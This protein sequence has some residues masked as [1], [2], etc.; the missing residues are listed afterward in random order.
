MSKRTEPIPGTSDIFPEESILWQEIETAA[1]RVFS[2]YAYGELRTPIMERT[3]VFLRSIGDETDI[4][5]KEMYTFTDR[6]GRSLTLRPEGTAGM[7]RALAN[8]GIAQGEEKRVYYCG[9]MFRGERPAA[10]RKRQFHQ[11]GVECVGRQAPEIDGENIAM[12]MH[13]LQEIGLRKLRLLLNSRGV[14]ADRE[15]ISKALYAWFSQ[16]ID[17]MCDDCRRR[18]ETNVWR[19]LDCKVDECREIIDR[20]PSI[21][22][23]LTPE[24]RDYFQHVCRTLDLLHIEYEIAPRLIR[25]LDYYVHTVFEVVYEGIGAQ[26]SIAGGG[27]YEIGLP[28]LKEPVR[29]VGFAAGIERLLLSLAQEKK[30]E[31]KPIT[32][33][34]YLIALGE[35]AMQEN[36]ELADKLRRQGI[37]VLMTLESRGLKSQLRS[38]NKSGAHYAV[39]SGDT[40]LEKGVAVCRDLQTST[41]EEIPRE[42]LAT[43]LIRRCSTP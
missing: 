13:F 31:T 42:T 29:G 15:I 39:I 32:V 38:A 30:G 12:L 28:G 9:P 23:L 14:A 41:Q 7:I 8:R 26:N 1:Q 3:D 21:T 22:D 36:F 19:I 17:S 18:L 16:H 11:I 33:D 25:G 4:V 43:E 5:Q 40:E 20:A 2:T 34:L 6:G 35:K 10:G 24:S 27:R 37:R